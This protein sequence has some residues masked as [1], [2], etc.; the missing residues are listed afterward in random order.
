[1]RD[2]AE[3]EEFLISYYSKHWGNENNNEFMPYKDRSFAKL[4]KFQKLGRHLI[5]EKSLYKWIKAAQRFEFLEWD[6]DND[7]C[8]QNCKSKLILEKIEAGLKANNPET[9]KWNK[10]V[11]T[12]PSSS[13]QYGIVARQ[14]IALGTNLGFFKG[15]L[16]LERKDLDI[17]CA[18]HKSYQLADPNSEQDGP[19]NP[20]AGF[21]DGSAFDS[22]FARHYATSPLPEAQ[23]VLVERLTDWTDH[24]QAIVFIA[25]RNIKE[26]QE[27]LIAPDQGYPE[28]RRKRSKVEV[29]SMT[30][31]YV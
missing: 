10:F 28:Q 21:I 12:S 24:N 25:N 15:K 16:V 13:D 9:L 17:D 5:D 7:L 2:V 6:G 30:C 27:L 8:K 23:N 4:R 1:M 20:E 22:C 11:K 26:G 31:G 14:D 29:A 18:F 19:S 3:G